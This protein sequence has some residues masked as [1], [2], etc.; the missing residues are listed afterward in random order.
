MSVSSYLFHFLPL[1]LLN[2]GMSFPFP[3]LKLPN[4]GREKYSK[5]ILFIHF[6]SIPFPPPKRGLRV[7]LRV[8]KGMEWNRFSRERNGM[9]WNLKILF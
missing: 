2:K 3:P 1:K 4:K 7:R 9:E 6:Y 8:Y 5:I